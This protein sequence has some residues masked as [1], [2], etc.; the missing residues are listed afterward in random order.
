MSPEFS[1]RRTRPMVVACAACAGDA[2]SF[3]RAFLEV[4]DWLKARELPT[5]AW[6]GVFH[7]SRDP[8][9]YVDPGT[10]RMGGEIWIPFEGEA[11]GEGRIE[12]RRLAEERIATAL[13]RGDTATIGETVRALKT[14]IRSQGLKPAD[15]H[16]QV[17]RK[18][19]PGH[20]EDPGWETEIQ[21]PIVG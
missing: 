2:T 21:I 19:V 9:T 11:R 17:Y 7:D 18:V 4:A 10:G 14:W 16:R 1:I 12:V 6:I 15:H 13:H 5:H 3:S 8:A 20:P